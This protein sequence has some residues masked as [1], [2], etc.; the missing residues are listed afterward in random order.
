MF[1]FRRGENRNSPRTGNDLIRSQATGRYDLR[2]P[3]GSRA[4]IV[5]L[6]NFMEKRI[7]EEKKTYKSTFLL[8]NT[9]PFFNTKNQMKKDF[10]CRN[11]FPILILNLLYK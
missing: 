2:T 1:L 4:R 3:C 5:I 8:F 6:A 7:Q 9:E 10:A 11:K